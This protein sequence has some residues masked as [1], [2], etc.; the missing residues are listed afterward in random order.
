MSR[1]TRANLAAAA[2]VSLTCILRTPA[3]GSMLT[4][5]E[6]HEITE[7]EWAD[8]FVK[9]LRDQGLQRPDHPICAVAMLSGEIEKGDANVVEAMV[10]AIIP[11]LW[12]LVALGPKFERR[13]FK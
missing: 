5:A 7:Y 11:F 8:P 1:T 6:A 9:R 12:L 13:Q 10:Q 3:S 2:L 4:C